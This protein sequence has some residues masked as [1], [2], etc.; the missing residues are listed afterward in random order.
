MTF[1][2]EKVAP[3]AVVL[4]FTGYCTWPSVSELMSDSKQSPPKKKTDLAATLFSPKLPPPAAR[5]P[6]SLEQL[7]VEV[8]PGKSSDGVDRVAVAK[9]PSSGEAAASPEPPPD[10]LRGLKLEATC[11]QGDHWLAMING[12]LYGSHDEI[13]PVDSSSGMIK[14]LDVEPYSVTLERDGQTA[15]LTY[16]NIVV[17]ADAA[18]KPGKAKKAVAGE[19]TALTAS[20]TEI[21]A[22]LAPA[23]AS[24]P[25]RQQEQS[26]R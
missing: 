1:T 3:L 16:A 22:L 6:F 19:D 25:S 24:P 10:P 11:V 23:E 4:A 18:M 9:A 20:Q 5:N 17:R 2:A 15:E 13:A 26:A 21:E 14:V 8:P 12:R 7:Q